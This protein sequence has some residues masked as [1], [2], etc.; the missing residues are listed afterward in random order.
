MIEQ[1]EK[2]NM[3]MKTGSVPEK[4]KELEPQNLR[5]ALTAISTRPSSNAS[6]QSRDSNHLSGT[7]TST[8]RMPMSESESMF[9][10]IS[11]RCSSVSKNH[12]EDELKFAYELAQAQQQS[13]QI[14]GNDEHSEKVKDIS[15]WESSNEKAK[16][17]N[18]KIWHLNSILL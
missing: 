2:R 14:N 1:E 17:N 18:V 3:Q 7:M 15:T 4:L 11:S 9:R 6:I 13:I 5:A 10:S 8:P 16:Y 12:D